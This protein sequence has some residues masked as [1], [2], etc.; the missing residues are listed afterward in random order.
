MLFIAPGDEVYEGMIIGEYSRDNDLDVN[1]CREKKLTNMR[2][3]GRDENVVTHPAPRH[4]PRAGIGVD[5]R[6]RA[7][8]GHAEVDPPAQARPRSGCR[9]F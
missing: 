5:R 1:I 8:R 2:A 7:G 4:G 3:A 9:R 6:R